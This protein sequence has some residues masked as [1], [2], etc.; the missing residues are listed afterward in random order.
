MA[1]Y[2][3]TDCSPF[4]GTFDLS[5]DLPI[6][7]ECKV[8]TSNSPVTGYSIEIYNSNNEII[9]P[10]VNRTTG[11]IKE[12]VTYLT[13]LKKYVKNRFPS[14]VSNIRNVNSGLNGTVLEI[15]AI[16]NSSDVDND[17]TVGRNQIGIVS[18]ET[19]ILVDGQTYTWKITLYQE[20]ENGTQ[21]PFPP[22]EAKFYDMAVANGT[23]IGS[24]EK[25]IQTALI[26]S[27]DKVVDNLVLL[28]KF[29]QPIQISGFYG[30]DPSNPV[31]S[32]TG[33]VPTTFTMTRS[34]ITGYDST[35]GY[36]YPSTAEG[37]AF[38][39]GQIVPE[40]ANGFQ[41]FKNG[42]NPSNLGATDMVDFI[43]DSGE[44]EGKMTWKT[45]A[46]NPEQSY[47]EQTYLVDS[48]PDGVFYPL[49][50]DGY[51]SFALTG[52]ERIIFNNIQ[53]PKVQYGKIYYGSPY[54]GIFEPHFSTKEISTNN[55][56]PS[57]TY[58][59]P[60][61]TY[62]FKQDTSV[63][64]FIGEQN[65]NFSTTNNNG[66]V[67]EWI[68]IRTTTSGILYT[69]KSDSQESF[70]Y[71]TGKKF[72]N[73][74][75]TI[76]LKTDQEVSADFLMWF[77]Q[78]V[79]VSF[80]QVTVVWNRTSDAANWGTISNKI[81]YCRRDGKNYEINTT[82]QV[83]EINKTPFKF[84]EEK[85]VRIFNTAKETTKTFGGQDIKDIEN[86]S[87]IFYT[88]NNT[89]SSILSVTSNN[90][91][92]IT[93]DCA[94]EVGNNY[95]IYTSS[96]AIPSNLTISVKYIPF[97]IQDYTGIIFYNKQATS[98]QDT[99]IIYIRPSININKNMIFK[100][101]TTTANPTW[102]N[103]NYFNKDYNYITYN[104]NRGFDPEV[105]KTRYQIKSF[106]KDSD[107][108]PFSIYK[109]PEI[110]THIET[111]NKTKTTI[112]SDGVVNNVDT[113][114]FTVRSNYSQNSY[115]QWKS[116]QWILYDSAKRT[117]L[118]KTEESYSG[119][120]L[121][122]FY[123]L[124]PQQYYI[125]SLILQTN[126]GKIIEVD[127]VIY[128]NFTEATEQ[129]DL[130]QAEFDCDTLSM[131]A[132]LKFL[133]VVLAPDAGQYL[134]GTATPD[135]N[136]AYYYNLKSDFYKK[137]NKTTSDYDS[138]ASVDNNGVL[139]ITGQNS[140][141]FSKSFENYA[142]N[143]N[144]RTGDIQIDADE[145]VVEGSFYF[146]TDY[147]GDIFS[148]SRGEEG[149]GTITVSIPEAIKSIGPD[150]FVALSDDI[151]KVQIGG[152]NSYLRIIGSNGIVSNSNE[153][154]DSSKFHNTSIWKVPGAAP[155]G[156]RINVANFKY[157][158]V[159]NSGT[160]NK[161]TYL[162]I[163][164]P[165]NSYDETKPLK[166]PMNPAEQKFSFMSG[167]NPSIDAISKICSDG[168]FYINQPDRLIWLDYKPCEE[169]MEVVQDTDKNRIPVVD[170]QSVCVEIPLK[171]NDDAIWKDGTYLENGTG[172]SAKIGEVRVNGMV[173]K[174]DTI[175]NTTEPTYTSTGLVKQEKVSTSI[176]ERE[177]LSQHNLSFRIF[178][179][180]NNFTVDQLRSVCYV[181]PS[182]KI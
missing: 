82:T 167:D 64:G 122:N 124:E 38:A 176:K 43:Y 125:L 138:I 18:G 145:I 15:P 161:S 90:G 168:P 49:K 129:R 68:K 84:V 19:N 56:A 141:D 160:Y 113:M 83:G 139:T 40:N 166:D 48:D 42:N 133:D 36:V 55:K 128:T 135:K 22:T 120:I 4:N 73:N 140:L 172:L 164:G 33:T 58:M 72:V 142:I 178:I 156:D 169:Q 95:I 34:L 75:E 81:V 94:F 177:V 152:S 63:E 91:V 44:F 105:D 35:Y 175:S 78:N 71:F 28:D 137:K 47:W 93:K 25:R 41:I 79:N 163:A 127:Y 29:V 9:F 162:N 8:D 158:E 57:G 100:E 13:D 17:T 67:S 107:Y 99:G 1:I 118:E 61:G 101:I 86:N 80:Y 26:D 150:G 87:C 14:L 89:I 104:G 143:S 146:S 66:V 77:S 174:V 165:Y 54:N 30:Y 180:T 119:E 154:Q 62:T 132:S 16:V 3:P 102:F 96:S 53:K 153:W 50:G 117:I 126:S 51:S 92:D 130:V 106:Y 2:K 32:W 171:W 159:K 147:N 27:D 114:N 76:T 7:F 74:T 31:T 155:N 59:L 136:T 148:V 5:A 179:N 20:V 52:S 97:N 65:L 151:N 103:I 85:P 60:A 182:P 88:E 23:V 11:P 108:N 69:S 131:K 181:S 123:G 37:N 144:T 24:N 10:G 6:V 70:V 116:Y 173:V 110:I 111:G 157:A 21:K 121:G 109:N 134:S 39:N 170:K 45:S 112:K 115:I 46:A 149:T 98:N 12:N